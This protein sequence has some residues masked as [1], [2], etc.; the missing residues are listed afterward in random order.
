MTVVK[1]LACGGLWLLA[2]LAAAEPLIKPTAI[3]WLLDCPLPSADR[4]AADVVERT[5]CGSVSVP[6]DYAAPRQGTLRLYVTRVGA[7]QP[8]SRQGVIFVHA[9]LPPPKNGVGTFAL[10]LASRWSA[11]AT[12]AY[13]SLLERYDVVELSARALD[14]TTQVEYAARDM[15]YVRDQLGDAQLYYLGNADADD[16]GTPLVDLLRLKDPA[17]ADAGSCVYRWVGEFLAYGK[18]PP[19]FTRC[20]PMSD[21]P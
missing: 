9:G 4:L 10:Q 15:E 3:D 18:Q 20:L 21:W 19:S 13:R 12:Q 5:Q 14:Q 7:R 6:R 2:S 17:K 16:I 1:H 11:N 8:L